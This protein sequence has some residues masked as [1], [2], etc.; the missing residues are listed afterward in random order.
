MK[1]DVQT[2]M[3]EA[4]ARFMRRTIDPISK[5]LIDIEI[6]SVAPLEKR[7]ATLEKIVTGQQKALDHIDSHALQFVGDWR[8][9]ERYYPAS[10]VRHKGGVY[11]ALCYLKPAESEPGRQGSYW[12]QII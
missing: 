4:C 1:S 6:K 10:V 8:A 9:D 3:L 11:T 5:R 7:I 12:Q 2:A